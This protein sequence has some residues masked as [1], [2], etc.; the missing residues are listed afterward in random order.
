[1]LWSGLG[2]AAACCWTV[3]ADSRRVESYARGQRFKVNSQVVSSLPGSLSD[4]R[5]EVNVP[6]CGLCLLSFY[7]Q[8]DE[9]ARSAGHA[10]VALWDYAPGR[11]LVESLQGSE[12]PCHWGGCQE[13]SV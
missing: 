3:P 1:M 12:A 2:R 6:I 4:P 11:L 8:G 10:P 9:N 13:G 7:Q 5:S